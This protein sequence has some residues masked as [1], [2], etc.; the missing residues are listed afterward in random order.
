MDLSLD[1]HMVNIIIERFATLV[2]KS[3]S[4]LLESSFVTLFLIFRSILRFFY[5]IYFISEEIGILE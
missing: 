5:V 3:K 2:I 4:I 1:K